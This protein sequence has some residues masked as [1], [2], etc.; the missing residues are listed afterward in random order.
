MAARSRNFFRGQPRE[1]NGRSETEA[2][3]S[4]GGNITIRRPTI[5]DNV[6]TEGIE[7]VYSMPESLCAINYCGQLECEVRRNG[8]ISR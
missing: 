6:F 2:V 5:I 8:E 4:S 3:V 1:I 7:Q